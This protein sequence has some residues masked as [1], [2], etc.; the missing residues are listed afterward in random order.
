MKKFIY[1]ISILL[2]FFVSVSV[3]GCSCALKKRTHT[4]PS[5]T[6]NTGSDDNGNQYTPPAV[7]PSD[8]GSYEILYGDE[9]SSWGMG[10]YRID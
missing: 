1:L 10:R 9:D 5:V 6:D 3:C 4:Q 8:D 7:E 2:I